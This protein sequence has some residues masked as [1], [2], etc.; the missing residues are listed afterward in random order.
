MK[1]YPAKLSLTAWINCIGAAQSAVFTVL[2][3]RKP[4]AWFLT[5]SVELCCILYAVSKAS[6]MVIN[7]KKRVKHLDAET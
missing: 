4:R 2:V 5:S 1:K 6:Y 7:T 3:Q